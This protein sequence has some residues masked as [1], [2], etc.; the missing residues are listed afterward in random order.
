MPSITIELVVLHVLAHVAISRIP[1]LAFNRLVFKNWPNEAAQKAL[2]Q[3]T[4]ERTLAQAGT[5]ESLK[6]VD[7]ATGEIIGSVTVSREGPA[8]GQ[9]QEQHSNAEGV[10]R[11]RTED[12]DGIHPEVYAAA[13]GAC[14]ELDR[15]NETFEHFEITYVGA[16]V[17]L[18]LNAEP[19]ALDFYLRL[20]F[21]ETGRADVDSSVGAAK[22][23][24]WHVPVDGDDLVSVGD[25]SRGEDG[26]HGRMYEYTGLEIHGHYDYDMNSQSPYFL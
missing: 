26:V 4:I 24:I 6:A 1:G 20:G 2:H 25:G 22:Q 11:G 14:L 13:V 18:T 3:A 7:D 15:S 23:W 19:E 17:P 5:V 9:Q 21:T 10:H 8:S 12:L 16:G